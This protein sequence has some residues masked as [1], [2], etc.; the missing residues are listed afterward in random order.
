VSVVSMRELLEAG[1]H[2][3]HQTR[4]WNPKM[5]RFIFTERGG[6]YIIDLQQTL[7]L[8]ERAYTFAR[9]VS[10]RGGSILFVGTKKQC[11]DS[12]ADEAERVGMPY[13]NHRWLGG[14]LTNWRT[15]SERIARMHELRRLRDEGQ[16][17]LLPPKERISMTA[18]LEKLE[19]N[20]GGV[21]DMKSVPDA[22][23]VIDLR[24]EQ[25]AV[26]EARRLGLPVIAL[27]DTNC[28]PDDAD[29]V[30]PGNDDAIRSC[31]LIVRVIADAIEAGKTRVTAEEM[32]APAAE[33]EPQAEAET[34]AQPQPEAAA[35]DEPQPEP[36]PAAVAVAET[37][38]P[39]PEAPA[40]S[41][42]EA[43]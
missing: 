29:Y 42:E 1:V 24:K 8:T 15:I 5:R 19:V 16:L 41:G 11:Q 18:E 4:R 22:V 3:G 39:E 12:I 10:E 23:F 13:V 20:L 27:V 17:D 43:R 31:S 37:A 33:A 26:R 9:N 35:A 28:D 30:I 36:E 32:A 2:F 38:K 34:E 21:A 7:D 25:L 40:E 14:L 6:I